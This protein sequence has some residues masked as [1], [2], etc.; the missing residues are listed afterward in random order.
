MNST[1]FIESATVVLSNSCQITNV[2]V[3]KGIITQIGNFKKPAKAQ[4]I[5]AQGLYLTPGA[6]D[7]HVHFKLKTPLGNSIDDFESG[8]RAALAGGTTT[9]IDFITPQQNKNLAQAYKE[10]KKDIKT[11]Y[12][13]YSLHQS[14]THWDKNTASQ[15]EEA[16]VKDGISSFKTY[17]AYTNSIGINMEILEKVMLQA[18]K[19]DALVM[20]HAENGDLIN[21]LQRKYGQETQNIGINHTLIHTV[22]SEVTTIKEILKLSA[23]TNCKTYIV[24]VSTKDGIKAIKQAQQKGV[25]IF[26]ETCPQYYLFNDK[27]YSDSQKKAIDFILSPPIRS[28]ENQNGILKAIINGN[29]DTI[30]TDH[31]A[32]SEEAKHKTNI[33]YNA[34]PHG[35]GG[36]QYRLMTFYTTFV[37]TKFLDWCDM[38]KL[39]AENPAKIFGLSKK[40]RIAPGYDADLVLW[41][42]LDQAKSLK[43]I[44]NQSRSNIFSYENEKTF[45]LPSL[46]IKSGEIV[47]EKGQLKDKLPQGQWISR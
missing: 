42:V 16:V 17:L 36:V 2:L 20:I 11:I 29:I 44:Q 45:I 37:K 30:S 23:K 25:A 34:I 27:V 1:L 19:L 35:I 40:G 46:I 9:I 31:C 5:P 22:E 8:S 33:A 10:R 24:H 12:T 14:I 15:M 39:T 4:L 38:V 32:F 6:I 43:T 47:L 26:A 21:S 7:A 28:E 13:D 41:K 3:E 18:A